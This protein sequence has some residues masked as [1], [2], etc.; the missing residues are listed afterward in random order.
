MQAIFRV[1]A[2]NHKISVE[3]RNTMGKVGVAAIF[4]ACIMLPV[5]LIVYGLLVN[6]V[7]RKN[8]KEKH[9]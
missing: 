6:I 4:A 1:P 3:Y 5:A 8:I 2:G 7:K 9:L